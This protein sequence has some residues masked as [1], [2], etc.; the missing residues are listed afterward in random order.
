LES[1][2]IIKKTKKK[3]KPAR[4]RC[5]RIRGIEEKEGRRKIRKGHH[6]TKKNKKT[7]VEVR[8]YDGK[9]KNDAM[10]SDFFLF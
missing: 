8:N 9:E 4:N 2:I 10:L 3:K 1:K 7:T 5:R 6:L